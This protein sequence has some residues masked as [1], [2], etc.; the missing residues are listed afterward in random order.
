MANPLTWS[1]VVVEVG[2]IFNWKRELD[3]V[4]DSL[5]K[6]ENVAIVGPRRI[7]NSS[8]LFRIAAMALNWEAS[9]V[10]AHLFQ[11]DLGNS[12]RAGWLARVATAWGWAAVPPDLAWFSARLDRMRSEGALPVLLLDELEGFALSRDEFDHGFFV[13][14]RACSQQS[15]WIVTASEHSPSLIT[16]PPGP[17]SPFSN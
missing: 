8:L 4:R 10:V 7:G 17:T 1:G 12:A 2:D 5:R 9:A 13:A 11:Q 15:L 6:R 3:R 16:D 14:L